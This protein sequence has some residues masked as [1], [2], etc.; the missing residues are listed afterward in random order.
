MEV[1]VKLYRT[2]RESTVVTIVLDEPSRMVEL[3][4]EELWN[5]AIGEATFADWDIEE[6]VDHEVDYTPGP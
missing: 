6:E 4:T 5:L 3:T 2:I 1:D